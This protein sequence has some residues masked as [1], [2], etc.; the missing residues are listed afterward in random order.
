MRLKSPENVFYLYL[1]LI[2]ETA[3]KGKNVNKCLKCRNPQEAPL[4]C[5]QTRPLCS[6]RHRK[7]VVY[8]TISAR[9]TVGEVVSL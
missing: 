3:S 5:P 4:F 2:K 9:K 1:N 6:R 7:L 8:L